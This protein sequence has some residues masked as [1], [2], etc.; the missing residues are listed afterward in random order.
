MAP[1]VQR[2][3]RRALAHAYEG[4]AAGSGGEDAEVLGCEEEAGG[5]G[6]LRSLI[7]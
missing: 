5:V 3:A 1:R 2:K 6:G 7:L 4:P